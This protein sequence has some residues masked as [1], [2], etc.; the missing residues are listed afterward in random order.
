[1]VPEDEDV[2]IDDEAGILPGEPGPGDPAPGTSDD[3][4]DGLLRVDGNLKNLWGHFRG[5]MAIVAGHARDQFTM[6][7]KYAGSLAGDAK[8]KAIAV[9]K[10]ARDYFHRLSDA[11]QRGMNPKR[12]L[13][14]AKRI[15]QIIESD[16]A[17]IANEKMRQMGAMLL[18]SAMN[19][20]ERIGGLALKMLGIA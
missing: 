15:G 9:F 12:F 18:K 19:F 14:D 1:M 16:L 2:V 5:D 20:L 11:L 13:I 6:L 3:A 7:A 4:L 8:G 17:S 10:K